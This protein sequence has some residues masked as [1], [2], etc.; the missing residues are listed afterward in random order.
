MMADAGLVVLVALV[1][2]YAVHR[3]RVRRRHIEDGLPFLEVYVETPL[4]VCE[5]R[6]PKGLYRRARAGTL[7]GLTG[8]DDPYEP[9]LNPEVTLDTSRLSVQECVDL[10][11]DKL[12]ELGYVLPHGHIVE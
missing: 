9:P 8:V 12:L 7:A 11:I 4:E 2:P 1:S 3:D 5:E 10:I 6:D